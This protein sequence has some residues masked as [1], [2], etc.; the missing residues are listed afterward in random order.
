ML[1]NHEL[2]AI[3]DGFLL[4]TRLRSDLSYLPFAVTQYEA[5]R[6]SGGFRAKAWPVPSDSM[7]VIPAYGQYEINLAFVPGSAIWGYTFTGGVDFQT[8]GAISFFIQDACDDVALASE[9]QTA[10][11][12]NSAGQ[13]PFPC[14]IVVSTPGLLVVK[15]ASTVPVDTAGVQ[16]ILWGGEPVIP[17]CQ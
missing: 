17:A 6:R 3:L 14:L 11:D 9:F 13:R 16:L 8:G 1:N 2:P 7:L 10:S 5:L 12:F 4:K 15:I